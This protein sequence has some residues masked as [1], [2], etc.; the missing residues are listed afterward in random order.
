MKQ[1]LQRGSVEWL[2]AMSSYYRADPEVMYL[3]GMIEGL[4]PLNK[5]V[6][7]GRTQQSEKTG[8][9]DEFSTGG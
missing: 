6:I 5:G 7:N 3:L 2:Q 8:I 9:D 1:G 4:L